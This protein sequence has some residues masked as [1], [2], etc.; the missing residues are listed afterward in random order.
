M[1]T[2]SK[3]IHSSEDEL[4][5]ETHSGGRRE[6]LAKVSPKIIS[7]LSSC[8]LDHPQ[9]TQGDMRAEIVR[10]SSTTLSRTSIS[11]F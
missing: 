11:L 1:G 2:I 7:D 4:T 6:A 10:T 3:I 8:V 5:S 9:A